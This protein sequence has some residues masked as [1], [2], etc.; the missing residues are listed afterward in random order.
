MNIPRLL[1]VEGAEDGSQL[2]RLRV[3]L[4]HL[5]NVRHTYYITKSCQRHGQ[6]SIVNF[7]L[8]NSS[9]MII[10]ETINKTGGELMIPSNTA[11][12]QPCQTC[13]G[14]KAVESLLNSCSLEK[15]IARICHCAC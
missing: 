7:K 15:S 8:N 10:T 12:C 14:T 11:C 3:H 5:S 9:I 4:C 1:A 2:G 6:K 13:I